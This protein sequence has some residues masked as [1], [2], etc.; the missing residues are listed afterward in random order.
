MPQLMVSTAQPG[1]AFVEVPTSQV[2]FDHFVHHY[3]GLN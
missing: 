3:H 1:E 2:F